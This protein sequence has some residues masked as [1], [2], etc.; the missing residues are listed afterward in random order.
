MI[1]GSALTSQAW[2]TWRKG[3]WLNNEVTHEVAWGLN[4]LKPPIFAHSPSGCCVVFGEKGERSNSKTIKIE[5]WFGSMEAFTVKLR[6]M[7]FPKNSEY[8]KRFRSGAL[9]KPQPL[10]L[11]TRF[12]EITEQEIKVH[13]KLGSKSNWKGISRTGTIERAA[14]LPILRS[15][16]LKPFQT[17]GNIFY[18]IAPCIDG[19][20]VDPLSRECE[21]LFPLT[22]TF[23]KENEK[24]FQEYRS[25]KSRETLFKNM[26]YNN[27][28]SQQL[29]V[30]Q[31]RSRQTK[32]IYNKSGKNSLK[33]HTVSTKTI[34]H[35]TLYW[36]NL[37]SDGE[38]NF[39]CGI[40][41][42]PKLQK[43]FWE[44]KSAPLHYD[45]SLWRYIPIPVFDPNNKLHDEISAVAMSI[46]AI[47]DPSTQLD[48]LNEP[49]SKLLPDYVCDSSVA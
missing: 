10:R 43:S 19:T 7:K 9:S 33:A 1:P 8:E 26:D 39:L 29:A 18:L 14:L 47:D 21:K 2:G 6:V 12:E 32:V 37:D 4:E 36:A 41:N 17:T 11:V 34:V 31:S 16:N 45:K 38:A 24:I 35:E 13:L 25:E 42:T 40:L 20:L 5:D 44:G 49:V 48:K 28:L 46:A 23:W 15:Q 30:A 3:Q 27:T 22:N